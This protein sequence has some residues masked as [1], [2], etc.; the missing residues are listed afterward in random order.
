MHKALWELNYWLTCHSNSLWW[1][2]DFTVRWMT[3]QGWS[4][5]S[6]G[7]TI[8]KRGMMERETILNCE[9]GSEISGFDVI[10]VLYTMSCYRHFKSEWAV[11]TI[12]MCMSCVAQSWLHSKPNL[13]FRVCPKSLTL[14]Y[15][16]GHLQWMNFDKSWSFFSLSSIN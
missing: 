9:M 1:Y 15:S 12:L 14:F 16:E 8:R 10:P 13:A 2:C 3:G 7:D 5:S 11:V 6:T 4:V